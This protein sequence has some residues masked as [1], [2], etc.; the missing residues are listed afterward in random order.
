MLH[1]VNLIMLILAPMLLLCLVATVFAVPSYYPGVKPGDSAT[2]GQVH[3]SWKANLAPV[4]PVTPV[5]DYLGVSSITVTVQNVAGPSVTARQTY[6]FANGTT[7][8]IVWV[9][10]VQTGTR[11]MST[12]IPWIIA[13]SLV[14]PESIYNSPLASTIEHTVQGVYAGSVRTVNIINSTQPEPGGFSKFVQ[15]WDEKTGVLLGFDLNYVVSNANYQ[16]SASASTQMTQT[17]LWVSPLTSRALMPSLSFLI[18]VFSAAIGS[19]SAYVLHGRR[20]RSPWTSRFH[21]LK[22]RETVT[23]RR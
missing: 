16:V 15:I 10:N 6:N 9:E 21:D 3:A 4:S 18:V 12:A 14:A 2:Y 1:T 20:R 19:V 23:G 17:S 22:Y 8:S 13:S 11:N 5:K 7:R